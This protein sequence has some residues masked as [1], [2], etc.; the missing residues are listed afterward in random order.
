MLYL[1]HTK[2]KICMFII[3]Y[4]SYKQYNQILNYLIVINYM[5]NCLNI[6]LLLLN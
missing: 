2:C 4:I 1:L 6:I 5:I 3:H